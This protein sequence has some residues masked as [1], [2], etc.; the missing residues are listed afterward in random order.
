[1]SPEHVSPMPLKHLTE[2]LL[3]LILA[4][5]TLI[6]GVLVASL[7]PIPE[8]F[9]PWTAVFVL[10][11]VYPAALYAMLRKNR[12]DYLFRAL[13]FAPVTIALLWIISEV[14]I[15]RMPSLVPLRM[16][17]TWGWALLPVVTTFVLLAAFCLHVIRRRVPRL[18]I[19]TLL[20]VPFLVTGY[21]SEA[22]TQWR[23]QLQTLLWEDLPVQLALVPSPAMIVNEDGTT[24]SASRSAEEEE[25]RSKIDDVNSSSAHSQPVA[26]AIQ[27]H[28]SRQGVQMVADLASGKT[29]SKT[30]LPSSGAGFDGLMLF[31]VGAYLTAVHGKTKRRAKQL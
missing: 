30:N 4:L 24:S 9:L 26:I 1:M 12:A 18:A 23:A 20:L 27:P 7:P 19:L 11:L 14:L 28:S 31:T 2:T 16:T 15:L 6:T 29:S 22:Q 17:L 21:V 13:H 8:G 25:W 5:A 3:V 10:T